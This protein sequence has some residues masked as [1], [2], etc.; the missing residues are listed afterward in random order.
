MGTKNPPTAATVTMRPFAAAMYWSCL[1]QTRAG[2]ESQ[3]AN[4]RMRK[5]P[6]PIP[7]GPQGCPW[8]EGQRRGRD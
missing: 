5:N 4:P 3:A 7:T 8:P 2:T 6:I 1:S